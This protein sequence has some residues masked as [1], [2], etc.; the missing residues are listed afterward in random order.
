MTEAHQILSN[1]IVEVCIGEIEQIK[2]K[3]RFDQN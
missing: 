3:Y 2:D 1:T